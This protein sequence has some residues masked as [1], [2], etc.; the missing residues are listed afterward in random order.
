MQR[1]RHG[2]YS[3]DLDQLIDDFDC[4]LRVC[5]KYAITLGI[6]KTRLGYGEAQF[7]GFRVNHEGS[8][9]AFKHLDPLRNLVP[10][11]DIHD[12]R[13]VLGLFV[14]SRKYLQD[15][16]LILRPMTEVLKGKPPTFR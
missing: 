1:G 12:L 2:N 4:F 15:Y 7:F 10:P 9:L 11:I 13:R 14:V 3:N 16:A 5:E 8:R 6:G